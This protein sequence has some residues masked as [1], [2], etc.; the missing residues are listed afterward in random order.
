MRKYHRKAGVPRGGARK[1]LLAGLG[2]LALLG[3]VVLLAPS[4][5]FDPSARPFGTRKRQ[6]DQVI[7]IIVDTLRPDVLSCYGQV[8]IPTPHI[9]R[10]A[11][12]GVRFTNAFSTAPWT[13][14]AVS[15]I[16]TGLSPMVH[17]AVRPDSKLSDSV[18]TLAESLRD[19]GYFTA[20]IGSNIFLKPDYNLS[21][22]FREYDFYPKTSRDGPPVES[23]K[24]PSP[25]IKPVDISTADLTKKAIAWLGAHRDDDFFLWIHYFDPHL[26]YEPGPDL[27]P[28]GPAPDRIGPRFSKIDEVRSGR[29]DLTAQEK[30]WIRELYIREVLYIDE[31]LGALIQ[32]LERLDI[33]EDALVVFMSD[34]GEEFW[35][36][37][38][39]EHGHTLYNELLRVPLIIKL[40]GAVPTGKSEAV[41]SIQGIMPTI[42][43]LCGIDTEDELDVHSLAPLLEER[44]AEP[45][46]PPIVSTG[47]LYGE[48]WESIIVE[49]MK[50]IRSPGTNREELYLLVNDPGE[51][52]SIAR[53]SP[54]LLLRAVGALDDHRDAAEIVRTR[55]GVVEEEN[56]EIDPE[57]RQWLESLGY[58]R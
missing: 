52:S 56:V 32:A 27:L 40:P 25:H 2:L 12:D 34:H 58:L 50:Y 49:G 1:G 44:V 47:L 11:R 7:L 46:T 45:D 17:N 43:D 33:Y 41:V 31:N 15:S 19:A 53:S 16:M 9:D 8:Q 30:E 29:L 21:Q 18:I 42:L 6:V 20:A 54:D 24:G 57:T 35:E 5:F 37:G 10:L 14:P 26:P 48:E 55:Y 22:G 36:H 23:Q 4:R 28:E 39:F 38:G 51:K 3:L 13:L